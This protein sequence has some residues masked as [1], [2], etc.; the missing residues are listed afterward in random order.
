L[1]LT[2]FLVI[3]GKKPLA[4][5]AERTTL[6]VHL[7]NVPGSLCSFLETFRK[8]NVNLSRLISRPIR[9]LPKEYAF[10]VDV[11]GAVTSNKVKAAL[12][13][14]TK[15]CVSLRVTGSYPVRAPYQS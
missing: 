9:G 14:A 15:I 5:G 3:G 4:A 6:A 12:A 11:E 8:Y 1:N 2:A 13:L 7:P 10:L